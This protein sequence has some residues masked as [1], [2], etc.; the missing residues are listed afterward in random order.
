VLNKRA[1]STDDSDL[2]FTYLA[3]KSGAVFIRR[4]GQMASE[5]R[6][7]EAEAFL[8]KI[9]TAS[10]SQAQQIMARVTGNYKR[11]N[12]RTARNRAQE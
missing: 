12:E 10:F 6:G 8:K 1:A 5:L 11:G 3:V 2:G 9:G 4:H 7:P